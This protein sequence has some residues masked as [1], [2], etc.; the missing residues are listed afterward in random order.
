MFLNKL[1]AVITVALIASAAQAADCAGTDIPSKLQT[2]RACETIDALRTQ[3]PRATLKGGTITSIDERS[4]GVL[5]VFLK[6]TGPITVDV[7]GRT[8]PQLER[9]A[10]VVFFLDS[11]DRLVRHVAIARA[12]ADQY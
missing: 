1:L 4:A 9:G 5:M 11:A 6:E 12:P 7:R 2:V 8:R 3:H 10:E